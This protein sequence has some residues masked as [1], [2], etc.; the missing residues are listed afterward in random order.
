MSWRG[1]SRQ[2]GSRINHVA[3]S[4][5][6]I[7]DHSSRYLAFAGLLVAGGLVVHAEEKEAFHETPKTKSLYTRKGNDADMKKVYKIS[8]V[9]GEGTFAVVRLGVDRRTDDKVA[10]KEIS[11]NLSDRNALDNEVKIMETTGKHENIVSLRDVFDSKET[12]FLVM[13]LAEGGELFDRIIE[14]GELSERTAST[15]FLSAVKGVAHLHS[16]HIAHLDIKPE[17][18][19]LTSRNEDAGI[20][21]ADFGLALDLTDYHANGQERSHVRDCVGTP[22][23]W[24]PEMVKNEPFNEKVDVWSLGCVLYIMLCGYHPFDPKGDATEPHILAAVAQ[25]K[26]D[27]SSVS[28][29]AIS[30]SA[31]DLIRHMLDPNPATRYDTAQCLRHPWLSEAGSLSASPLRNDNIMRLRGFRVLRL[32]RQ[33]LQHMLGEAARDLF[34]VFDKD[35]DGFLSKEELRQALEVIGHK[36][37]D[38]ELNKMLVLLDEDN[39]GKISREEFSIVLRAPAGSPYSSMRMERTCTEDLEI[40]FKVFDRDK[41][42]YIEKSDF[43]HIF[44][45]MG[46]PIQDDILTS[47]MCRVDLNNDGK[48]DFAEFVTYWRSLENARIRHGLHASQGLSTLHM[49][50]RA[51]SIVQ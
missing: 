22:A 20:K 35:G 9:L 2:F 43:R 23:Y 14:R 27:Q 51:T 45:L 1:F 31:K 40:L 37:S 17:N 34:S 6:Y 21:I 12:L 41:D 48:V 29:C 11:K 18:L 32:L 30:E 13:D 46:S 24:A 5:G 16:K 33:G 26:F 49:K 15:M 44:D 50:R 42:G 7:N 19:L 4:T 3:A 38:N 8:H 10:I 47:E 28:Y 25:G 36:V 39:D